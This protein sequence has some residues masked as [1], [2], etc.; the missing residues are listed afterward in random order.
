MPK[1]LKIT[2][3]TWQLDCLPEDVSIEGNALASGDDVQDRAQERWIHD[4]LGSGNQWAWCSVRLTGSYKG[5]EAF[6]TLG[7]CCYLDEN[8]FQQPGGYFDDM[9]ANVL[10]DLQVQLDELLTECC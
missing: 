3:V 5:L 1:K 10:A 9:R 7:C 4:Q 6:D 8:D 2:D